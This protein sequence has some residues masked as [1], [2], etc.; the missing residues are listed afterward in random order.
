MPDHVVPCEALTGD[1]AN[2]LN[3]V[4]TEHARAARG[5]LIFG[6]DATASRR[7]AWDMAATLTAGMFREAGTIGNLDLQL[8]FYRGDRECQASGW[9]SDAGC[10]A[11][12]MTKIECMAGE[13]QIGRILSHAIKETTK[14]QVNALVFVGDAVEEN[15][16]ILV[17]KARE[18]GRLGV[19][20]FIF[21]EGN[22]PGVQ[23]AFQDIAANTGGAYAKFD[24]QG[25]KRL[26]ELLQA[27]ARYVTG[28]LAAL[29]GR[30][31]AGSVLLI[32]QL[33]GGS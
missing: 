14:L 7:P 1:L 33:S 4:K 30:K 25:A 8:V 17:A 22:D 13:T 26:G 5:R 20:A 3:E 24:S 11:R 32:D 6:L 18:L 15:P 27:V 19:R 12:M 9:M 10:L 16:D 21:Q 29:E 2:F 31:D 28:G 23:R